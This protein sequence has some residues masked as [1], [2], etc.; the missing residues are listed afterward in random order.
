V[1]FE[2][3]NRPFVLLGCRTGSEGP[4]IPPLAGARILL[5]R[6]E[7]VSAARELSDHVVLLSGRFAG[8]R[9]IVATGRAAALRSVMQAGRER[10]ASEWR[11]ARVSNSRASSRFQPI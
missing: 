3:L 8:S 7:A 9:T 11:E 10:T 6:V 2:E 4:Q 1:S 5:A